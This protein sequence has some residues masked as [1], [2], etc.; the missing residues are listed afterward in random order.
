MFNLF[1]T[2]LLQVSNFT[3]KATADWTMLFYICGDG[4]LQEITEKYCKSIISNMD[5]VGKSYPVNVAIEIDAFDDSIPTRRYYLFGDS[6]VE[7]IIDSEINM[8]DENELIKFS[9]AAIQKM[10]TTS[11]YALILYGHGCN[12]HG[13]IQDKN[14]FDWM[15]IP[16][17]RFKTAITGV[18]QAIGQNINIL[19]LMACQMQQWEVQQELLSLVDL[20]VGCWTTA[21]APQRLTYF[22]R[23]LENPSWCQESLAV[24]LAK[25][26]GFSAIK[27]S[28]IDQLTQDI[29]SLALILKTE[30][31]S[32]KQQ[33]IDDEILINDVGYINERTRL[34]SFA[35]KLRD[36][37][38]LSVSIRAIANNI[39]KDIDEMIVYD[40]ASQKLQEVIGIYFP[41][42]ARN[43]DTTYNGLSSSVNTNWD[44]YLK[45]N[46]FPYYWYFGRSDDYYHPY[47][48]PT[49][50][51]TI[52]EKHY[53]FSNGGI[54]GTRFHFNY[55]DL[56]DGDTIVISDNKG[57]TF[58]YTGKKGEFFT[59]RMDTIVTVEF[60]GQFPIPQNCFC[61]D[62]F[63]WTSD[64]EIIGIAET[65][66]KIQITTDFSVWPNPFQKELHIVNMGSESEATIYDISGRVVKKLSPKES[67]WDGE[68]E[69]GKTINSGIYF[70]KIG[71]KS[72][73]FVKLVN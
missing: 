14:P 6:S 69:L 37:P 25:T 56:A 10:G 66:E 57:K 70:L 2:I 53:C 52:K 19:G 27:T 15:S 64:E 22:I 61:L 11:K 51:D 65:E 1:F 58:R 18:K 41:Q 34:G 33:I 39:V 20:T 31:D 72:L 62:N 24:A 12:W 9:Q 28:G 54:K 23:L 40:P 71:K 48:N 46:N 32:V 3:P 5:F 68:D 36:D 59:P 29:N 63:S 47:W 17:K 42:T 50:N 13:I 44:E 49:I 21:N 30:S 7:E 73:K 35:I 55:L 8:A 4:N 43:Y 67:V 16:N 45:T 38:L 60:R 26:D